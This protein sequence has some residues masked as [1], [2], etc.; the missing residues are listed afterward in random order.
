LRAAQE[1]YPCVELCCMDEHRLGLKPILGRVWGPTGQRPVARVQ[2]RFK[3]LYLYAF[4]CPQ[5]GQNQFWLLPEVNTVAFGCALKAFAYSVGAGP[6][7]HVLLVLDGAGWHVAHKLEIP[8]GITLLLLPPHSPELQPAEHLWSVTDI[9]LVNQH[10]LTLEHLQHT[11]E[12]H[13]A[14]LETQTERVRSLTHFHWWP[15]I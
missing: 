2:H 4:V 9:P 14:W 13:L 3:W 5:S 15:S 7:K 6:H 1:Q 10:F 12:P 11:L 8:E